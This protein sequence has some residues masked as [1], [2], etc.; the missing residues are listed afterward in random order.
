LIFRLRAIAGPLAVPD[1]PD[2][3]HFAD[4]NGIVVELKVV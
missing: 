1:E 2:A 3:L 4:N